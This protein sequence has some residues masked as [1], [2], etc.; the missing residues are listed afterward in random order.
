VHENPDCSPKEKEGIMTAAQ[1]AGPHFDPHRTGKHLGPQGG[2][3]QGDLPRIVANADSKV[4]TTVTVPGLTIADIR[5]RSLMIHAAGDNY[6]DA[7]A[8]LGGGGARI[9]CGVVR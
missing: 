6:S 3:H 9:A 2:G 7:P 4:E 1:A 5:N 8:P